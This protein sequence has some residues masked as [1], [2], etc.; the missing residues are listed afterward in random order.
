MISALTAVLLIGCA[1]AISKKARQDGIPIRRYLLFQAPVFSTVILIIA[2][3]SGG[4]RLTRPY[5]LYSLVGGILSFGAFVVMLHSLTRGRAST[6]YAIFRLSFVF[7]SGAAV[8][9]FHEGISPLK[10]IGVI[11]A[12]GAVLLF[13]GGAGGATFTAVVAMFVN[14]CFQLFL[15]TIAGV[16]GSTA[17][18]LF[19]MS[20]VFTVLTVAYNLARPQKRLTVRCIWYSAPNGLLMALGTL[21]VL[22]ALS[23]GEASRVLPVVQLSFII[24]AAAAVV[25]L[26]EKL[27][28]VHLAGIVSAVL[29]IGLLALA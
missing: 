18:F 8:V 11:L 12:V 15:K 17:S 16:K 24:T 13:S 7:S 25:F 9:L 6:N 22:G 20:L 14:A 26:G 10:I 28:R 27:T 19:M 3:S 29:A 21:C 23:Q 5:L 1:D 2:L 4:L